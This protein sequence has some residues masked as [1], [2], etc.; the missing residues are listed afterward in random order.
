MKRQNQRPILA[1]R[2]IRPFSKAD[3]FWTVRYARQC[4]LLTEE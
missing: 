3:I 2:L 4:E 1:L